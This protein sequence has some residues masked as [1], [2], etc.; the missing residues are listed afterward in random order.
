[1]LG[2]PPV[3]SRTQNSL[4]T[5]GTESLIE[6]VTVISFGTAPTPPHHTPVP[7]V[8]LSRPYKTLSRQR[9]PLRLIPLSCLTL[10]EVSLLDPAEVI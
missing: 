2:R 1:M 3:L 8:Y 10:V 9:P 6:I 4:I 5:E 7:P